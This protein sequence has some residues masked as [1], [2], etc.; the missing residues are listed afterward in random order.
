MLKNYSKKIMEDM[1]NFYSG[2]RN[3]QELFQN[4]KLTK[5]RQFLAIFRNFS[6]KF[7]KK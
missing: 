5:F 2:V 4:R 3:S 7:G 1:E 6:S